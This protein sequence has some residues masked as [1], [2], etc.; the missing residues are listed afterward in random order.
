MVKEKVKAFAD[1]M[2]LYISNPKNSIRELLQLINNFSEMARYKINS[3][4]SVAF[5][6]AADK[7]A[8]KEIRETTS[9]I[10]A[11]NN[12]KFLGLMLTKQMKDL[13]DNNFKSLRKEI[14]DLCLCSRGWLYLAPR[15]GNAFSSVKAQC[16]SVGEC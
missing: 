16:P 5:L 15:G 6:Y 1:H 14:E 13:Y 4:K 11:T 12:I 3:S 7:H 10:I 9:F 2:V 8:E